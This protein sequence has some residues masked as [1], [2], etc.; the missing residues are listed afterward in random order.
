MGDRTTRPIED[1]AASDQVLATD[2]ETGA[3]GPRRVDAAIY[4]P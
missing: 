2:P 1:I 4:T 3:T